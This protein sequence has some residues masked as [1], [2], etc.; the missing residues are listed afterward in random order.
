MPQPNDNTPRGAFAQGVIGNPDPNK[1]TEPAAPPES[2]RHVFRAIATVGPLLEELSG[3]ARDLSEG[4]HAEF[5]HAYKHL[6]TI[7]EQLDA[8]LATGRASEKKGS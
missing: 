6:D 3:K 4:L 8:A 5:H 1:N 2:I 7:R